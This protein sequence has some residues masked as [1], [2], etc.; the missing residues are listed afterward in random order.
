[1]SNPRIDSLLGVGAK[2]LE[3]TGPFSEIVLSSRVRLARNMSNFP[4]VQMAKVKELKEIIARCRSATEAISCLKNSL[5]VDVKRLL[6]IDLQFL[7]ERHLISLEMAGDGKSRGLIVGEGEL[8]S[9]MVNEED[10]LRLQAFASGLQLE[11]CY[12]LCSRLDDALESRLD[13]A[14]SEKWG[15]LTACPTNAGTG[16]RASILIHLPGLVLTKDVDK[17]LRGVN[18]VGLAVR[19]FYGEGSEVKGNFF[20][21]SNQTTLGRSEEDIINGLNKVAKQIIEYERNAREILV[22]SARLEIEDK[23]WRAF[24]ILTNARMLSS[25]EII[26]LCSAV[27]LGVGLGVIRS[28]STKDLNELLI[29]TQPAHLQKIFDVDMEPPERDVKRAEYVRNRLS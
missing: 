25:E 9:V 24:G 22:Q 12:E 14:F 4:F 5:Y 18:Q 2:W 19:G 17:V 7:V 13:Y 16:M 8:L 1:M 28:V 6:P 3:A 10:H 21:V 27:R 15:F 23:I 29:L 26:N 20:Q 11:R